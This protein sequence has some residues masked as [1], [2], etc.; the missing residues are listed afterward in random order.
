MM[1]A[2]S[3]FRP[4]AH[5]TVGGWWRGI[6]RPSFVDPTLTLPRFARNILVKPSLRPTLTSP[7]LFLAFLG[8][9]SCTS[10]ET[11][12]PA[13]ESPGGGSPHEGT[14]I[15]L[16]LG[17]RGPVIGMDTPG[18]PHP[19]VTAL[20]L[21]VTEVDFVTCSGQSQSTTG[22]MTQQ[23][24]TTSQAL[25]VSAPDE[26][27]CAMVV[28]TSPLA[29]GT[30]ASVPQSAVGQGAAMEGTDNAGTP[31]S[32]IV[33]QRITSVL[34]PLSPGLTLA[35]ATGLQLKIED[36]LLLNAVLAA[37]GGTPMTPSNVYDSENAP[38]V[39][40]NLA[41]QLNIAFSL[42]TGEGAARQ[43]LATS[44]ATWTDV[45]DLLCASECALQDRA[46]CASAPCDVATCIS[47]LMDPVCGD[48]FRS[49]LHCRVSLNPDEYS[50]S[51]GAISVSN[52]HCALPDSNYGSC[53]G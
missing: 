44:T 10:T 36:S 1:E 33:P 11:G 22:L 28:R 8:P 37:P 29:V 23:N 5:W 21:Q 20:W 34:T 46:S 31:F 52:S 43:V 2:G 42:E 32:A 40:N 24:L 53:G 4:R 35:E 6:C 38:E 15:Q 3:R 13:K 7:L 30:T 26:E 50:C 39:V 17:L 12:N 27:I 45:D 14:P 9:A 49:A 18:S 47:S 16:H 48:A 25:T 41:L 51:D 19:A